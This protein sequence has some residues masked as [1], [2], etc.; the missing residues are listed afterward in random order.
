MP[1]ANAQEA[2]FV[3]MVASA[4]AHAEQIKVNLNSPLFVL[5]TQHVAKLSC[6]TKEYKLKRVCLRI[7]WN[8]SSHGIVIERREVLHRL[9]T[10]REPLNALHPR[11]IGIFTLLRQLNENFS[12]QVSGVATTTKPQQE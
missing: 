1:E 12:R 4:A 5:N 10:A 8:S 2:P 9:P 7:D 3:V 6:R 11:N